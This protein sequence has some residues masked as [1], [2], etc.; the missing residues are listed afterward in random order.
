M[1]EE[2]RTPKRGSYYN[3]EFDVDPVDGPDPYKDQLLKSWD[4][5]LDKDEQA[6]KK[7]KLLGSRRLKSLISDISK[8]R[9]NRGNLKKIDVKKISKSRNV[10]VGAVGIFFLLGGALVFNAVRGDSGLTADLDLLASQGFSDVLSESTGTDTSILTAEGEE[11]VDQAQGVVRY[12]TTIDGATLAV[13]RQ[14]IPDEFLADINGSVKNLALAI[15]NK[16]A[17]N[18]HETDFGLIYVAF[19]DSGD[20]SAV[21]SKDG[22]LYFATTTSNITAEAWTAFANSL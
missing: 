10:R 14:P 8:L 13:T 12:K 16:A 5:K 17:L 22:N 4:K 15:P 9:I 2:N 1:S 19:M 11:I 3:D 18:R 21:F 20:Q 6:T 7:G